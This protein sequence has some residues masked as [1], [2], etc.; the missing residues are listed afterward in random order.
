MWQ[1]KQLALDKRSQ[2]S[3]TFGTYKKKTKSHFIK[4]YDF[5]LKLTI[6]EICTFQE[7]SHINALGIKIELAIKSRST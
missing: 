6:I 3:L 5:G 4:Y 7:F 2:V 1:A